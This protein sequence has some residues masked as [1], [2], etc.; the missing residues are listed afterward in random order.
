MFLVRTLLWTGAHGRGAP[1]L[2]DRPAGRSPY[3]PG[4]ETLIGIDHDVRVSIDLAQA[5]QKNGAFC[6]STSSCLGMHVH[7]RDRHRP[8]TDGQMMMVSHPVG[9][10]ST[11]TMQRIKHGVVRYGRPLVDRFV[12]LFVDG[13]L[14]CACTRA[15]MRPAAA[16]CTQLLA[17]T[18]AR[19]DVRGTRRMSHAVVCMLQR[20]AVFKCQHVLCE[21]R[22]LSPLDPH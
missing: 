10:T 11:T 16:Q 13:A 18:C 1:G 6:D 22:M 3:T 21:P 20:N 14:A 5:L 15:C 9:R 19:A 2:H 4:D 7:H 12:P 17:V 8:E